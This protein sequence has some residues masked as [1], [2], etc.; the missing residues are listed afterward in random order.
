MVE[1]VQ[2][3]SR[4]RFSRTRR[5]PLLQALSRPI[6]EDAADL[7]FSLLQF[8]PMKRPSASVGVLTA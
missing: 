7:L 4:I 1:N 3:R 2:L 8:N 6:P 5:K